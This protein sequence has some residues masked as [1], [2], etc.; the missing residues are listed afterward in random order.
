M[1]NKLRKVLAFIGVLAML[2]TLLP[3]GAMSVTAADETI[4]SW[5]FEDGN[6][7]FTSG[8]GQSII[9]DPDNSANHVLYWQGASA[10]GV[11]YKVITLEKN[12]DYVIDSDLPVWTGN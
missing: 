9:V 10:W 7:G 12:T 11:I 3:M 6:V 5:N 4:V 1:Q 2:C 8:T